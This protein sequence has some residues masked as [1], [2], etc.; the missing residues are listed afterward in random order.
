MLNYCYCKCK[1]SF[2]KVNVLVKLYE[3]RYIRYIVVISLLLISYSS[4]SLRYFAL[5]RQWYY[6]FDCATLLWPLPQKRLC[7]MMKLDIRETVALGD[8]ENDV[9]MLRYAGLGVCMKQVSCYVMIHGSSII[10]VDMCMHGM[11]SETSS[12]IMLA[13]VLLYV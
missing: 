1:T 3:G 4:S 10:L 11:A 12:T 2:R 7:D 13:C 5:F 9:E 6:C 8:S